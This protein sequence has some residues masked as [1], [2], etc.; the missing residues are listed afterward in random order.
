RYGFY[1]IAR[2]N[3]GNVQ[4]TPAGAQATTRV[5]LD[6]PTSSVNTLPPVTTATGFA[7]GWSASD[8]PARSGIASFDVF[9]SDNR[10]P[11]APWPTATTQASA[12]FNGVPGHTYAFYSVAT[13]E[14]GNHEPTPAGAEA[15]ITLQAP[16]PVAR[17]LTA[18]LEPVRVKKKMKLVV[19]VLFADTGA[20]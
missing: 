9:V 5:D 2:D 13:D 19:Q 1:S 3:G 18:R 10:G 11:F 12:A 17:G 14:A 6:P 20:L 15:T 8:G 4:S 16:P 7:V